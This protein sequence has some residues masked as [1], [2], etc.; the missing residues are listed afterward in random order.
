[1]RLSAGVGR[2]GA[3]LLQL[4]FTAPKTRWRNL[5][6]IMEFCA[7][8]Q[9]FINSPRALWLF[10]NFVILFIQTVGLLGRGISRY[11]HTE[12]HK[13][14]IN[15]HRHPCLEWDSNPRSQRS[16]GRRQFMP[17]TGRPLLLAVQCYESLY[18]PK[19]YWEK[20]SLWDWHNFRLM[21]PTN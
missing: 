7:I 2:R 4:Q 13:H 10:F 17:Q 11:L 9:S 14:R 18:M 6:F 20:G 15:I 21:G 5:I 12:Q 8:L 19:Q 3:R 1:M 16:R